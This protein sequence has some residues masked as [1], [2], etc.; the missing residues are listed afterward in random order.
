MIV[1]KYQKVNEITNFLEEGYRKFKGDN[2]EITTYDIEGCFPHMPKEAINLAM[3][4]Y[5]NIAK[6]KDKSGIWVPTASKKT[7][8][9]VQP[10]FGRGTW[11]P[12][13]VIQIMID[14]VL[15]HTYLKMPN[16]KI[17]KQ[18]LGIPMGDPLSP[19][20]TSAWMEKEWKTSLD[21][22]TKQRFKAARYIEKLR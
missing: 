16:G 12:F 15:E 8:K 21:E 6:G 7:C 11:I 4:E 13:Q 18:K 22:Q 9:W 10:R 3:K 2:I 20:L 14:F 5:M 1:S 17:L 19:G